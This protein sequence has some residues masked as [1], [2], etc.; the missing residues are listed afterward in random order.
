MR[1]WAKNKI[2]IIF[3]RHG[4]TESNALHRYLGKTDECLSETGIRKLKEKNYEVL[5]TKSEVECIFCGPMSRCKETAEI[6]FPQNQLEEIEKWTEIDFGDFEGKNFEELNGNKAYQDWI[7]SNGTLP[8]PNGEGREEFIKRS[9][10][11]FEDMLERIRKKVPLK[12]NKGE[13]NEQ[14]PLFAAVLHGG[15]IMSI[16]STLTKGDYFDYQIGNGNGYRFTLEYEMRGNEVDYKISR[17][18]KLFG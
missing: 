3:L 10:E 7:D 11:G 9:V 8:F 18:E 5:Y 2:E 13:K 14:N 6:I 15:N 1:D 17:L 12:D 4:E 16:L